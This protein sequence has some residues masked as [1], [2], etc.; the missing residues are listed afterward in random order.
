MKK[1][2]G[3]GNYNAKLKAE[4][5]IS[6]EIAFLLETINQMV[7]NLKKFLPREEEVLKAVARGYTDK[8]IVDMFQISIKTVE[9]HKLNIKMIARFN[10]VCFRKQLS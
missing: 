5:W 9:K 10:Q 1:A 4:S 3:Q 6:K 2:S 7:T 8:E